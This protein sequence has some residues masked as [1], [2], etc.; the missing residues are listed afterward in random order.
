VGLRAPLPAF[1]RPNRHA[2]RCPGELSTTPG[3]VAL[4]GRADRK[5]Q[6][7]LVRDHVRWPVF[8]LVA[9]L[10]VALTSFFQRGGVLIPRMI[11]SAP[12]SDGPAVITDS[13]GR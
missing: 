7:M 4:I 13:Q 8:I 3:H 1:C 6:V 2:R 10:L 9:G 12:V 11:P 5:E